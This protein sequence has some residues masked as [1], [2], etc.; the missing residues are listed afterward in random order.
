MFETLVDYSHMA[1]TVLS[2]FYQMYSKV[3]LLKFA[4]AQVY[5]LGKILQMILSTINAH[6]S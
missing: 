2:E 1:I 5:P 4:H 6:F 3:V